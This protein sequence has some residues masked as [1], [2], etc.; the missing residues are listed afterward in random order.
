MLV[1]HFSCLHWVSCQKVTL[2]PDLFCVLKD[3]TV[4]TFPFNEMR[5]IQG[6]RAELRTGLPVKGVVYQTQPQTKAFEMI[7]HFSFTKLVWLI[8]TEQTQFPLSC[9]HSDNPCLRVGFKKVSRCWRLIAIHGYWM[10]N[11]FLEW[12][13]FLLELMKLMGCS[14]G[15][16]MLDFY[17]FLP[18]LED[19]SIYLLCLIAG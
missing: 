19:K 13:L 5:E 12:V 11:S 1:F 4:N 8:C 16:E 17:L 2:H 3:E 15:S 7:P 18:W 9:S 10:P 14:G 6:H